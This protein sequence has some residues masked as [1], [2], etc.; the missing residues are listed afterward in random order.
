MHAGLC[1]VWAWVSGN[2]CW[3]VWLSNMKYLEALLLFSTLKQTVVMLWSVSCRTYEVSSALCCC[4]GCRNSP[5]LLWWLFPCTIVEHWC[6]I[7]AMKEAFFPVIVRD[8]H[9]T[10]HLPRM[11]YGDKWIMWCYLSSLWLK[12]SLA[13]FAFYSFS[14]FIFLTFHCSVAAEVVFTGSHA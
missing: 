12:N 4:G 5:M 2:V 10:W 11:L 7:A 6:K 14:A 13:L 9:K 8:W 1:I 3:N